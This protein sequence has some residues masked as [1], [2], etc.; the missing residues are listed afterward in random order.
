MDQGA[1]N[2]NWL[3]QALTGPDNQTVAIG[4]LN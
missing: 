1:I 4:M 3:Q 2:M